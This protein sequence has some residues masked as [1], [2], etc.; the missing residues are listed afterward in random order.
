MVSPLVVLF[1][2]KAGEVSGRFGRL[3]VDLLGD[4]LLRVRTIPEESQ[5]TIAVETKNAITWRP[6][7]SAQPSIKIVSAVLPQTFPVF[8]PISRKVIDGKKLWSGFSAASAFIPISGKRLLSQFC[9][10]S[11]TALALKAGV[12]L[13][14]CGN[15][16]LRF[17][18]IAP[19]IRQMHLVHFRPVIL[20]IFL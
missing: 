11:P 9:G 2:D 6:S 5:R 7:I 3:K 13:V 17:L 4:F 16:L 15:P 18:F 12:T 19:T 14:P 10:P 1:G 8:V 20:Y